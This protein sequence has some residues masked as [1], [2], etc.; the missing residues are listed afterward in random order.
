MSWAKKMTMMKG[1]RGE[2]KSFDQVGKE[3]RDRL[4]HRSLRLWLLLE[5]AFLNVVAN[6]SVWPATASVLL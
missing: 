6:T 1:S 3:R 4:R 2:M 5:V